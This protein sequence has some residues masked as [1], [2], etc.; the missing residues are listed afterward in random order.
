T[1]RDLVFAFT[2]SPLDAHVF[3]RRATR[4]ARP[5]LSLIDAR[6]TI[7]SPPANDGQMSRRGQLSGGGARRVSARVRGRP[8]G[9]PAR[10]LARAM[11]TRP[12]L[13]PNRR[14]PMTRSTKLTFL[15]L[16]LTSVG[17]AIAAGCT[18]ARAA[19]PK[20]GAADDANQPIS[21]TAREV[22]LRSIARTLT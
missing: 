4:A 12:S 9:P 2:A 13:S 7:A 20:P 10:S 15:L 11:Q 14:S 1:V 22:T 3:N 21:A 8:R 17:A 18:P 16:A 19:Q 6:E 5:P